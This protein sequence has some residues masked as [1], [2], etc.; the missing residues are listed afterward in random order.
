M[1]FLCG[2]A[3]RLT[4]P[5]RLFSARAVST[6]ETTEE[7]SDEIMADEADG[8][9]PPEP[10]PEGD[11][12]DDEGDMVTLPHDDFKDAAG[13]E[14]QATYD[15]CENDEDCQDDEECMGLV[16]TLRSA[17]LALSAESLEGFLISHVGC[18]VG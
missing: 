9:L 2:R 12:V 13:E 11:G 1:A 10:A 15:G 16:R 17:P 7:T 5:F 3:G 4:A 14:T 18:C 6:D 8:T